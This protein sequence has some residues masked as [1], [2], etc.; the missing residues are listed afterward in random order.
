M[1]RVSQSDFWILQISIK[2]E[3]AT[4]IVYIYNNVK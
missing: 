2:Y 4:D 3:H 1:I